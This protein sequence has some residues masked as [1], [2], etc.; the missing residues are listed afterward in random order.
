MPRNNRAH[1]AGDFYFDSVG[2]RRKL[3]DG[4]MKDIRRSYYEGV[5]ARELSESYRVSVSLILTVVYNTP[6]KADLRRLGLPL[7]DEESL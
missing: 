2:R 6:R 4:A 5:P 1:Q 7:P 3:S